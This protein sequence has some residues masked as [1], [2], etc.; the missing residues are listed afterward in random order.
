[1]KTLIGIDGFETELIL[2]DPKGKQREKSERKIGEV[3]AAPKDG[4]KQ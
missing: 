3:C 2:I 1:M 4:E